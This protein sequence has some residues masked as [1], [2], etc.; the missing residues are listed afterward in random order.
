MPFGLT[1]APSLFQNFIDNL[2]HGMVDNFYTIYIDDILIY[3]NPKKKHQGHV[4][5]VFIA[6]Q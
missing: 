5:K 3:T 4:Q 2:L 6:L 1:N